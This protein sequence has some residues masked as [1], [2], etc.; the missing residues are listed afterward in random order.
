MADE[1]SSPDNVLVRFEH[2]ANA[3]EAMNNLR[4]LDSQRQ[5]DLRAATIIVRHEDGRLEI[6]DEIEQDGVSG[7]VSGGADVEAEIAAADE[8]QLSLAKASIAAMTVV[9][10]GAM[11][12]KTVATAAD[13]APDSPGA[14]MGTT[15]VPC[16]ARRL[17]TAPL[18]RVAQL[19]AGPRRT[20]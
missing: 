9:M 17:R 5:V 19:M 6:K 1:A 7:T 3:Y 14:C 16:R 8:A 4:E 13:R 11:T 20:C 15:E 2:D 10:T 18:S 12:V